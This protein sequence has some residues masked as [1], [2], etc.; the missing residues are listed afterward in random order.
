M[1]DTAMMDSSLRVHSIDECDYNPEIRTFEMRCDL[2][3]TRVMPIRRECFELEA[4]EAHCGRHLHR[5]LMDRDF[6]F[7]VYDK[8]SPTFN[9]PTC[10]TPYNLT[11]AVEAF[12]DDFSNSH[13]NWECSYEQCGSKRRIIRATRGGGPDSFFFASDDPLD[14]SP[15]SPGEKRRFEEGT[16]QTTTKKKK[17]KRERKKKER[18]NKPKQDELA[19]AR[20]RHRFFEKTKDKK[21]KTWTTSTP[22]W[23]TWRSVFLASI[24]SRSAITIRKP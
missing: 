7:L 1:A 4:V 14:E 6:K 20:R 19:L 17:K 15:K 22:P 8:S 21:K 3:G 10:S 12:S 11:G 16:T 24:R 18:K 23:A 5:C 9:C 2:L 13:Y